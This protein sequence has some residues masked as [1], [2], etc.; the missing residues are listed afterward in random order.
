MLQVIRDEDIAITCI[1]ETW[2]DSQKGKHTAVIREEGY[3]VT[4]ANRDGKRGGGVAIIYEKQCKIKKGEGSTEK[5][6]SF[7]YVYCILQTTEFK[8]LLVCVY[9]LQEVSCTTFC[10]EFEKFM[11]AIFHKGDQVIV[12]G[13]FNVWVEE[14]NAESMKLLTMM[15][16]FGL[17]QCIQG[18]THALGHTLDQVYVNE[19]QMKLNCK[20]EDRTGISTDHFPITFEL[21]EIVE[22]S[23]EQKI[24]FRNKRDMDIEGL[25]RDLKE[26]YDKI[27]IEEENFEQSYS[28]YHKASQD[29]T[30][31]YVPSITKIVKMTSNVP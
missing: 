27:A 4:H 25:K 1:C 21:P 6:S 18:A 5:Y 15:N 28:S 16:V 26:A 14:Q 22:K 9:R 12:T 8:V 2:F 3:E 30:N 11:E 31:K 10:D 23:S 24:T 29:I 7:E 19:H 13:D 17:S 20:I